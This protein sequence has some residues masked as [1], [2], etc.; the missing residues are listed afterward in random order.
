MENLDIGE[1]HSWTGP[2]SA[3]V[4]KQVFVLVKNAIFDK[5]FRVKDVG[6][7]EV[8]FRHWDSHDSGG[9]QIIFLELVS[10]NFRR[11]GNGM[12]QSP[13]NAVRVSERFP[14]DSQKVGTVGHV[15]AL[16]I[17]HLELFIKFLL[18]SRETSQVD[19]HVTDWN[20]RR[21]STS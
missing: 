8:L 15:L 5:S 16:E 3:I 18:N 9:D 7:L 10:E 19:N 13:V 1:D 14:Q 6:I 21:V 20:S 2:L 4:G 11:L 17:A 12:D